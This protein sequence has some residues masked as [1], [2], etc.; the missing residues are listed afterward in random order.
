[1]LVAYRASL[2]R[3]TIMPYQSCAPYRGFNIDL[4]ATTGKSL[5][6]HAPGRR[7]KVS[8]TICSVGQSEQ[9]LASFPEQLEFLTENEAF[10]Y[11]GDR[12]H[13]FIDGMLAANPSISSEGQTTYAPERAERPEA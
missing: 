10:R 9:T 13:M 1:M 4:Q 2:V 11:A 6:L 3:G 7:Y 12:A 5:C 8:W